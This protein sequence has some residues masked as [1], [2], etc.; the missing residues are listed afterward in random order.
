MDDADLASRATDGDQ[1]AWA[2]IYDAYADRLHDYCYSI[3]RDRHEAADVLHDAFVTAATKIGQLRDPGRLRPWLYAICRTESLAAIR[4]R[5]REAPAEEVPD[6]T[7]SDDS[8]GQYAESELRSL[9]TAAAGGLEARDRAV[10]FLHL[11]GGLDGAELGTALGVSAHHATVLLGRVRGHVERSLAAL[12]VGRTGRDDCPELSALLSD[13]DGTLSP[14]I[15]KRVARHIDNCDVCGERRKRMVSPLALLSAVPVV[16]APEELRQRTLD[17]IA[18]VAHRRPPGGFWGSGSGRRRAKVGAAAAAVV[19]LLI[20]G[21]VLLALPEPAPDAALGVSDPA[22]TTTTTASGEP[23]AP[24]SAPSS[25]GT[26]RSKSTSSTPGVEPPTVAPTTTTT[27]APAAGPG[28][29]PDPAE[30]EPPGPPV[31][32]GLATDRDWLTPGTPCSTT[33]ASATV[34]GTDVTRVDLT[35]QQGTAAPQ[36]MEMSLDSGDRYVGRIGPVTG[37]QPVTW[38]VTATDARGN[39]TTS[40]TE[41]IPTR[42][43]C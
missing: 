29:G 30:P 22:V 6:V 20:T 24:V 26:P 27:R 34:T 10:L 33:S 37:D 13:W 35:W 39:A 41:T 2:E 1:G 3:V 16:P 28:P 42:R 31:V 19:A 4:R 32:G 23:Q 38:R 5:T 9:V 7:S 43:T 15:R 12:L 18:L 21:G 40:P 14:L 25:S 17:D 8:H 11:R 36:T